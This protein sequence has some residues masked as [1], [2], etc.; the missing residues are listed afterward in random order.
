MAR[1]QSQ[2]AAFGFLAARVVEGTLILVGVITVLAIVSLRNGVAGTSGADAP[3]LV[4]AGHT[5]L[6][7]YDGTFLLGQ[8]LM[9][10]VSAVCL[11]SVMYR[12]GL[13]PRVIPVLGLVGAPLLLASDA[14]VLCGVLAQRSPLTGVAALPIAAW[15]ISLGV[16]L[17]AKGFRPSPLLAQPE[18][19]PARTA[20]REA[21]PQALR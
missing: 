13:V 21:L 6:A 19:D 18:A 1:R 14:A 10:V 2:T 17:L 4:T 16:W 3:S 20:P 11:G 9:P 8:S 5:M 15:E 7:V 12:S